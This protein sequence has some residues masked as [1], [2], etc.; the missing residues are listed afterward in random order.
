MGV[1]HYS[2]DLEGYEQGDGKNHPGQCIAAGLCRSII[3]THHG[4]IQACLAL[5]C[6][7]PDQIKER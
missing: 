7:H 4:M 5:F 6:G 3:R 2:V 1:P